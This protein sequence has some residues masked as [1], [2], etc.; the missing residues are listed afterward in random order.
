M[1]DIKLENY[2][3]EVNARYTNN[4]K[5]SKE[6]T[7]Y[8]LNEL[9]IVYSQA[10]EFNRGQGWQASADKY[11]RKAFALHDMLADLGLYDD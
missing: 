1:K 9:A 11:Q 3:I 6:Q 5:N 4:D 8:F 10:A 7:L 2:T